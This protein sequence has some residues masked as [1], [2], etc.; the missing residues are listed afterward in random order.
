M[1]ALAEKAGRTLWSPS[2]KRLD[3]EQLISR[4]NTTA[5]QE[6]SDWEQA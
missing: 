3:E 5:A 2:L 1:K 6:D 4:I